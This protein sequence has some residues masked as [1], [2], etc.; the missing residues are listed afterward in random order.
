[1]NLGILFFLFPS[2]YT[3]VKNRDADSNQHNRC[4]WGIDIPQLPETANEESE[5]DNYPEP[6]DPD[7]E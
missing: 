5:T 4:Q 1:M 6:F 2:R 3:P 7:I